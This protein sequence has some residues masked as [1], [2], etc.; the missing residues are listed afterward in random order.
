[1][2]LWPLVWIGG[3]GVANRLPQ[4]GGR[5]QIAELEIRV[6][7]VVDGELAGQLAGRVGAHAVGDHQQVPARG[8]GRHVV[9]DHHRQRVL[10][11]RAAHAQVAH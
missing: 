2:L 1:M 6:R 5:I 4:R 10:I 11:V 3:V 9:G 7:D 8:P